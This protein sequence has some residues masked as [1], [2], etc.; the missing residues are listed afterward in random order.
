MLAL[1]RCWTFWVLLNFQ[2]SSRIFKNFRAFLRI[3]LLQY[4]QKDVKNDVKVKCNASKVYVFVFFRASGADRINS[5]RKKTNKI[6]ECFDYLTK[7]AFLFDVVA[8]VAL[9]QTF[10]IRLVSSCITLLCLFLFLL[11]F[12]LCN[13]HPPSKDEPPSDV[14]YDVISKKINVQTSR[15]LLH[16]CFVWFFIIIGISFVFIWSR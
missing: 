14:T 8:C 9:P 3:F 4:E 5:T 15:Y 16:L 12:L 7:K 2:E 10:F 11:Y 1:K 6:T 13:D